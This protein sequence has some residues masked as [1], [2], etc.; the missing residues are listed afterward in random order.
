LLED[1]NFFLPG[2]EPAP[3]SPDHDDDNDDDDDYNNN[4]AFVKFKDQTYY[5]LR[6]NL[7]YL[8]VIRLVS[9]LGKSFKV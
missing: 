2:P 6:L 3:R 9:N 7:Y 1:E 5:G 8:L 4:P